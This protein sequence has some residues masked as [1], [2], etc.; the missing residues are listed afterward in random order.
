MSL[1]EA[2]LDN[3]IS[4]SVQVQTDASLFSGPHPSVRPAKIFRV[5]RDEVAMLQDAVAVGEP[6]EIQLVYGVHDDR[7]V[8][9]I[10]I[11]MRTPGNDN[12]LAAG[13]LMTEGV[14]RDT[15]HITSIATRRQPK[16]R[17]R[18]EPTPG[19]WLFRPDYDRRRFG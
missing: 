6:L 16:L 2:Q 5:K 7:R 4:E 12:E 14:V 9:S 3:R 17:S 8:K 1:P 15:T 10:S 18:T 13:F 11:T 19:G